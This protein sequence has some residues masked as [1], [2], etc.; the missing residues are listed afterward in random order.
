MGAETRSFPLLRRFVLPRGSRQ[1]LNLEMWL[2][3]NRLE[4]IKL[5][6]IGTIVQARYKPI[7]DRPTRSIE[8]CFVKHAL[9]RYHN[10]NAR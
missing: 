1:S 5:R 4:I 3:P 10:I 7:G 6:S 9:A 2:I 8:L